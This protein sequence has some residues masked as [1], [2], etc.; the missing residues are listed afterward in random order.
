MTPLHREPERHCVEGVIRSW[1]WGSWKQCEEF[2]CPVGRGKCH[3]QI[4]IWEIH[5]GQ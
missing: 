4:E 3:H 2:H 5:C 1:E